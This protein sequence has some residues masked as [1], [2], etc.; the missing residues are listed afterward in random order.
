MENF[1]ESMDWVRDEI[2]H[3]LARGVD[4]LLTTQ[5]AGGAHAHNIDAMAAEIV[6]GIGARLV[7]AVRGER[8]EGHS[9]GDGRSKN[10][11]EHPRREHLRPDP[12]PRLEDQMAAVAN[13]IA[14]RIAKDLKAA[15]ASKKEHRAE[16]S[17]RSRHHHGPRLESQ[18]TAT[19]NAVA[20]AVADR[21]AKEAKPERE[22][23]RE[24]PS[25][26]LGRSR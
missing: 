15:L 7:E 21:A 26:D 13:A 23:T 8:G 6:N 20:Q 11:D 5:P 16:R 14:E 3:D 9:G 24:T 4:S 18:L 17:E 25:P 1:R 22:R 12:G 2:K 10:E 19:A